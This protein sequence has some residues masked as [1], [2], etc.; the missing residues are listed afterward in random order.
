VRSLLS[1]WRRK[2]IVLGLPGTGKS[3]L[4]SCWP[5][6]TTGPTGQGRPVVYLLDAR[7]L[8]GCLA[9]VPDRNLDRARKDITALPSRRCVIAVTHADEDCRIGILEN[10][11]NLQYVPGSDA[12]TQLVTEDLARRAVFDGQPRP[13]VTGTMTDTE[14]THALVTAI[15]AALGQRPP[16]FTSTDSPD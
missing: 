1:R 16:T 7:T 11:Y 4:A 9:L 3:T 2:T 14:S 10:E 13:V 5:D 8:C 12:Y 15:A 6:A